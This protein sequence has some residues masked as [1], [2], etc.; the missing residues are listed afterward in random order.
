MERVS[1]SGIDAKKYPT[2]KT[3]YRIL[4][5]TISLRDETIVMR[6]NNRTAENA[7]D[8]EQ[9]GGLVQLVLDF[10]AL[11]NFNEHIE[12]VW[13]VRANFEIVPTGLL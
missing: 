5:F 6:I 13:C 11:W 1:A 4:I 12:Q 10:A 9:T 7:I 2:T 8:T 3:P